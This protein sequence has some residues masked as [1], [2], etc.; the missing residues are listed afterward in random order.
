MNKDTQTADGTPAPVAH[1]L[2]PWALTEDTL[3]IVAQDGDTLIFETGLKQMQKFYTYATG[4]DTNAKRMFPVTL[5]NAARIVACVNACRK[6]ATADLE[7][8]HDAAEVQIVTK[9]FLAE[10]QAQDARQKLEIQRLRTNEFNL[11]STLRALES[12]A[13]G[14]DSYERT[15]ALAA[16]TSAARRLL[17]RED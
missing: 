8:E 14:Y 12:A 17:E 7:E 5:A 3:A 15:L 9:A 11:R 2:E 4:G 13:T 10:A 16:A 6:I 1:T